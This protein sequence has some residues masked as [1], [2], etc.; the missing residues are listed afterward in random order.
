M[1]DNPTTPITAY[2]WFQVLPGGKLAGARDVI[3]PTDAALQARHVGQVIASERSAARPPLSSL[4]W[5]ALSRVE[6]ALASL[7]G[8]GVLV[9]FGLA[10]GPVIPGIITGV[11]AALGWEMARRRLGLA[12]AIVRV[13]G[14]VLGVCAVL[15]AV[16]AVWLFVDAGLAASVGHSE[17][18]WRGIG[19]GLACAVMASGIAELLV[20]YFRPS[21]G[22]DHACPAPPPRVGARWIPEC[23]I[24]G[25]RTLALAARA[26]SREWAVA[27]PMVLARVRLWGT[28]F[29]YSDGYRAGWARI[30][31]LYDDRSGQVE[32]PAAAYG[33]AVEPTPE[34]LASPTAKGPRAVRTALA[35]GE[36]L[37]CW[38]DQRREP[39]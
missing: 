3:W 5:T 26:A 30:D 6:R 20:L 27:A 25:Y 23:G 4:V 37:R 19:G 8:I 29:P 21:G 28:V 17:S 2:R 38:A 34:G 15:L 1:D 31:A 24:Y 35:A 16:G 9:A 7:V 11:V 32:V 39:R 13:S 18:T 36:R 22:E 10:A 14:I 12:E 33:V